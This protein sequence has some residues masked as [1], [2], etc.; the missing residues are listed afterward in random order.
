[1]LNAVTSQQAHDDLGAPV[2]ECRVPGIPRPQGSK[3]RTRYGGMREASK[4]VKEWRADVLAHANSAWAYSQS[5]RRSPLSGPLVLGVEFVF[6]RPARHFQIC[7]H[8]KPALAKDC[9]ACGGHGGMR[10]K[11]DAPVY[12]TGK[13]DVSK[14]LRAVEDSLTDAGVWGDDSQVVGYAGFPLTCK[15]FARLGEEPGVIIRVWRLP[16]GTRQSG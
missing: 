10:I 5:P 11:D 9:I 4:Y 14:L 3:T 16:D 2:F 1:M 6:H 12:V 7:R 13:P 15:R 8:F